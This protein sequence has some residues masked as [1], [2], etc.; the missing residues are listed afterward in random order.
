MTFVPN[1]M[2]TSRCDP[3]SKIINFDQSDLLNLGSVR[4]KLVF[5]K[6]IQE[7]SQAIFYSLNYS[8]VQNIFWSCFTLV[9]DLEP[10]LNT[11]ILL[12]PPFLM[13]SIDHNNDCLIGTTLFLS[14]EPKV[15]PNNNAIAT[16]L[17]LGNKT[18]VLTQALCLCTLQQ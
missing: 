5:L 14:A 12:L 17:Q 8:K 15:E 10:H 9:Q 1:V 13:N 16:S 3:K 7:S 6:P 2:E 18:N 11:F 4:S